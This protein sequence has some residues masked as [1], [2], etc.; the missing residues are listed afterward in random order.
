MFSAKKKQIKKNQTLIVGSKYQFKKY[1]K[2]KISKLNT[3]QQLPVI[4]D[5]SCTGP[6]LTQNLYSKK[7]FCIIA[8]NCWPN[9]FL[10]PK[11]SI[12]HSKKMKIT[13]MRYNNSISHDL[14][15]FCNNLE[16]LDN[17]STLLTFQYFMDIIL[18]ALFTKGD[19]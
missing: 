6:N 12:P 5:G 8:K 18:T 2:S 4:S 14:F 10:I 19:V 3:L 1:L 7:M 15:Q 13:A 9:K 11:K 17:L 16:I